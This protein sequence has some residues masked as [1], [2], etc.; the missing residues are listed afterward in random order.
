M[1]SEGEK[2]EL[3]GVFR[4][5][6]QPSA[7]ASDCAANTR[8]DCHGVNFLSTPQNYSFEWCLDFKM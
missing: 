6:I 3:R 1:V 7:A 2:P 5:T 8:N 4:V